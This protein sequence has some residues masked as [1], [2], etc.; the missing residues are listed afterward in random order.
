MK[1]KNKAVRIFAKAIKRVN[2]ATF[3]QFLQLLVDATGM[4]GD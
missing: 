4:Q 2:L 1:L 3:I